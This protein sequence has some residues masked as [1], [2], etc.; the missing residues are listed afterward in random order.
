MKRLAIAFSLL[1][2]IAIS[3]CGGY[4]LG[5][6]HACHSNGADLCAELGNGTL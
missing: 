2:A 6:R 3:A 1:A 4:W 5:F